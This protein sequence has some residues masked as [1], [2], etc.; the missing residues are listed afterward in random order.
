MVIILKDTLEGGLGIMEYKSNVNAQFHSS[1]NDAYGKVLQFRLSS[2]I[3][4]LE[5][6]LV[7]LVAF[8]IRIQMVFGAV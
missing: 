6:K 4:V 3:G 5:V 8:G 1:D 7:Y 2:N